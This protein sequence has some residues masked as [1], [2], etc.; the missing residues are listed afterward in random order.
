MKKAFLA[1]AAILIVSSVADAGPVARARNLTHRV[2]HRVTHPFE[3]RRAARCA[4]APSAVPQAAPAAP[5][6]K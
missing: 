1:I 5:A 6:K 3:A 4:Q 2:V